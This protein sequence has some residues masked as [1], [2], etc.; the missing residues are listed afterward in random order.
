MCFFPL[1]WAAV[2]ASYFRL[3]VTKKAFLLAGYRALWLFFFL[4][5]ALWSHL[6]KTVS[7]LS[8]TAAYLLYFFHF[9]FLPY[10][11][12]I[13]VMTLFFELFLKRKYSFRENFFFLMI[14]LFLSEIFRAFYFQSHL[15]V[16]QAL[17]Q[18][19]IDTAL[20]TVLAFLPAESELDK[21][22]WRLKSFWIST[23]VLAVS[24]VV[25]FFGVVAEYGYGWAALGAVAVLFI[26]FAA[27][28]FKKNRT[29]VAA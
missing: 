13:L 4:F 29:V 5:V 26:I 14:F 22:A 25:P 1:L 24:L 18:P 23:S 16:F 8:A 3:T 12:L 17:G 6:P 20:M 2:V 27:L 15:N 19:L 7:Y 28:L 9:G 21:K 11:M 10:F